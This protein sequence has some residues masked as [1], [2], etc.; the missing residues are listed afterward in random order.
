MNSIAKCRRDC[1]AA[2]AAAMLLAPR[3]SAQSVMLHIK[4]INPS[5]VETQKVTVTSF[6]PK[7]V[8]PADVLNAADFEIVYDM[9]KGQY[10]LRREVELA[11]KQTLPFDVE[12]RDIW[13]IPA[14]TLA[15]LETHAGRLAGILKAGENA[16]TAVELRAMLDRNIAAVRERQAA[17]SVDKGRVL[18]HIRAYESNMELMQRIRKDIGVMENLV[19]GERKDPGVLLGS[20]RNDT[21][22]M[23]QEITPGEGPGEAVIRIRVSN[24]SPKEKRKIMLR[25]DLPQEI[26]PDDV[27]DAGGLEVHFD[28]A[29]RVTY[30][31]D[32]TLEL[33]P[34]K[35]Q[36]FVVKLRN[37]WVLK[38][39]R[40]QALRS[41]AT[42]LLAIAKA[43][44]SY[45]SI[46]TLA[47][48]VIKEL[49]EIQAQTPPAEI[50]RDYVAFYRGQDQRIKVLEA[51]IL[52]TKEFFQP[53]DIDNKVPENPL[54]QLRPPTLRTTWMI[55][56]IILGFLFV[57]SLLF[58]LR[59][60]GKS[61]AEIS[62]AQMG[63]GKGEPPA[64]QQAK[65]GGAPPP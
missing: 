3:A 49:D 37:R 18:D 29:R 48:S 13:V 9:Y 1:V 52:K 40:L 23:L 11:P 7:P 12:L 4:A 21:G 5:A 27:I 2:L 43:Q 24:P 63:N 59:W 22:Q 26:G 17:T 8:K 28:N 45:V 50:G 38:S 61:K 32:D 58:F 10:F 51:K 19:I 39:D 15:E 6:L 30:V 54:T 16:Q 56:Y 14:D 47:E 33:E 36:E 25:Q 60:Y 20:S 62:V 44:K 57:F 31:A 64:G 46:H 53:K 55:I 41:D 35:E 42:N 34:G 65:G